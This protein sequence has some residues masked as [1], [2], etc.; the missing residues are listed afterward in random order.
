VDQAGGVPRIPETAD[1]VT[2]I[3]EKL[4]LKKATGS[5]AVVPSNPISLGDF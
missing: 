2:A 3:L 1:Y 4:G 5:S